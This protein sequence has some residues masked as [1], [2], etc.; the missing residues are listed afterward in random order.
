MHQNGFV[1]KEVIKV[2][3]LLKNMVEVSKDDKAFLKAIEESTTKSGD[4]C[5]VPLPFKKENLI[6]PNNR[7][8]AVQRVIDT[9]RRLKKVLILWR[10]QTVHEQLVGQGI[11]KKDGWFTSYLFLFISFLFKFS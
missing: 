11:C 6:I 5:V 9:K 4:H 10:L 8:Q 1:E 3:D 7:K 2:N